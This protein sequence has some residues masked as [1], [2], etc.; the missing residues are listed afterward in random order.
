MHYQTVT[1]FRGDA[2]GGREWAMPAVLYNPARQLLLHSKTGSVIVPIRSMQFLAV[3]DQEEFAFVD[4]Q[5]GYLV[6]DGEGGRPVVLS[7][8]PTSAAQRENLQEPVPTEVLYFT[9]NGKDLQ[10]RLISAFLPALN[11]YAERQRA[12]EMPQEGARILKW[13]NSASTA[14]DEPHGQ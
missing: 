8:R 1:F 4:S 10:N 12:A 13:R 3:I 14:S 5:G 6:Q 9:A 2:L 11:E 7:W